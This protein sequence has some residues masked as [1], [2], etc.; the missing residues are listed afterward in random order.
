MANASKSRSKNAHGNRHNG[1]A[2]R[3]TTT[4][5]ASQE[6]RHFA[7]VATPMYLKTISRIADF[8]KNALSLAEEQTA[9]WI[10]TWKEAAS[11]FP[12]SPPAV[13]FDMASQAVRTSLETQKGAIDLMVE[14]SESITEIAKER[15]QAYSK[16]AQS[17][18]SAFQASVLRSVEAQKR[19]LESATEQNRAL[20]ASTRRKMGNGPGGELVDSFERGADTMMRAQKS[21]LDATVEPFRSAQE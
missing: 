21:I 4:G 5:G 17:A 19:A 12:L 7:D 13:F 11:Q 6:A 16:I 15:T 3:H 10:G 9:E 1:R 8:Q 18:S 20:F 14:Q 2:A